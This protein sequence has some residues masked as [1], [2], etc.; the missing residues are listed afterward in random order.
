MLHYI[1]RV[2]VIA[3]LALLAGCS[4][5]IQTDYAIAHERVAAY[6]AQHPK[7]DPKTRDAMRRF[8][9]R[10]GMTPEQV[11]ATWGRPV[12]VQRYRGGKQ[13]YWLFGCKYPHFC[14][15]AN[16]TYSMPEVISQSHVLFENGRV[17]SWQG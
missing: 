8:E 7:V 13:Q 14:S 16:D 9:L 17:A 3:A 4:L 2:V 12:E 6:I 15:S 1:Q 5:P 10:N 11:I